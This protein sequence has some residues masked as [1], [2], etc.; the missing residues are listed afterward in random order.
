MSKNTS[1]ETNERQRE[2]LRRARLLTVPDIDV[3]ALGISDLLEQ[4]NDLDAEI[5]MI[6][7]QIKEAKAKVWTHGEYADADWFRRAEYAKKVRGRYSQAIQLRIRK[8]KEDKKNQNLNSGDSMGLTT[9]DWDGFYK[10]LRIL[11][12]S[13]DELSQRK[14]D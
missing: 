8:M 2:T 11:R 9:Q 7:N 10:V 4:K 12:K 14:D 6:N 3:Q 5:Q 1:I 13:A